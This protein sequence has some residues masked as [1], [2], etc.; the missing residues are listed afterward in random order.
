MSKKKTHA[1][2]LSRRWRAVL[3]GLCLLGAVLLIGLDRGV[4][5]GR[6]SRRGGVD[7]QA[8]GRD[9]ARYHAKTFTVV[10][11]VDGDTLDIDAPDGGAS[12]TGIR[13]LGIDAPE[14]RGEDGSPAFFASEA[15]ACAQQL[16]DGASVTVYLDDGG[17][18]RGKYGR[19]LAY[20]EM[21]DERFLNEVLLSEGCVYADLRFPHSYYQ[22][23]RQL[24]ASA[25]ALGKGLWARVEREQWPGWRRRMQ[26]D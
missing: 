10:R 26:G 17:D 25:R 4:L 23:Y 3:T 14:T 2:A 16:V 22:R 24:E 7:R 19:L 8:S 1:F 5:A 21:S 11:V 6:W 13:L 15:S 20:L 9:S 12:T 18:S